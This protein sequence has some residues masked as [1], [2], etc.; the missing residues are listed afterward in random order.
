MGS[1]PGWTFGYVPPPA[2]WNGLWAGKLDALSGTTAA[3]PAGVG[4]GQPYFD[5]T[6]G[7]PI[8]WNGTIWVNAVGGVV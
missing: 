6:L 1:S 4:L 2:E 8:W 3:R 5:T 7:V